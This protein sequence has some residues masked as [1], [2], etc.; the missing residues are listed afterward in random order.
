MTHRYALCAGA[1]LALLPGCGPSQPPI[2]APR[3]TLQSVRDAASSQDLIY[4]SVSRGV[5]VYAYPSGALVQKLTALSNAT[6]ECVDAQQNVWI[7]DA[8][9]AAI[10]KYAHGGTKP[11]AMLIDP[12]ENPF[13]C[14]VNPRNGDLAVSNTKANGSHEPGSVSVYKGAS[15]TPTVYTDNAMADALFLSYDAAGDLF[16]DGYGRKGRSRQFLYAELP[17]GGGEIVNLKLS[18]PI[19][20]PG[21]IQRTG[22]RIALGGGPGP[23]YGVSIYQVAGSKVL[24]LTKCEEAGQGGPQTF[25]FVHGDVLVDVAPKISEYK[26]SAGGFPVRQYNLKMG[27]LFLAVSYGS[28]SAP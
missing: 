23:M 14:S 18:K 25:A 27:S 24:K 16:V 1:A 11:I 17:Y 21:D 6:G 19:R 8:G 2:S 20:E 26:Y 13:A 7:V 5:N 28:K 9:K 12:G 15:G 10:F 4:V 22:R 3:M